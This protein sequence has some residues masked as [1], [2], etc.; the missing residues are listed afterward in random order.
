MNETTKEKLLILEE[1]QS[2]MSYEIEELRKR[3]RIKLV[4]LEA[5]EKMIVELEKKR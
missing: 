3:V 5:I 4:E 1:L 2:E